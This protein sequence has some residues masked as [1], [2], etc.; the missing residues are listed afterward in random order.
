MNNLQAQL[1]PECGKLDLW[2]ASISRECR[3]KHEGK[4]HCFV[5]PHLHVLRCN[6]C[7]E[8]TFDNVTNEQIS[9]GLRDHLGLLSPQE[10]LENIRSLGLNL[11]SIR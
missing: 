11:K 9:Q 8:V 6:C 1:C 5:V 4:L 10:I 2:P 7:G 3:T